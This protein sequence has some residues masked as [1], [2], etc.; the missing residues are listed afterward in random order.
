[1]LSFYIYLIKVETHRFD[2]TLELQSFWD[3][4]STILKN[5]NVIFMWLHI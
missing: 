5:F 4:G 1:M 3:G 2:G